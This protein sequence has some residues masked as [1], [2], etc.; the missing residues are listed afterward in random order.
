MLRD[1]A[2]LQEARRSLGLPKVMRGTEQIGNLINPESTL[3]HLDYVTKLIGFDHVGIGTDLEMYWRDYP[4]MVRGI[5]AGL[6]KRNYSQEQIRKIFS[7]NV[8]RVFR[9]NEGSA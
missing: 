7:G 1:P 6:I 8:L 2:E 5:A 3:A 4:P 9:D